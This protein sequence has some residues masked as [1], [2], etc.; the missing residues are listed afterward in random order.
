[1]ADGSIVSFHISRVDLLTDRR[2][3]QNAL[4]LFGI[5]KDYFPAHVDDPV[6]FVLFDYLNVIQVLWRHEP[7]FGRSAGAWFTGWIDEPPIHV[8]E[9]FGILIQLVGRKKIGYAFRNPFYL[10]DQHY[11]IGKRPLA[12]GVGKGDFV[13]GIKGDPDPGVTEYRVPMK[14]HSSSS[15]HSVTSRFLRRQRLTFIACSPALARTRRTVFLST[16]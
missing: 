14:D 9:R 3:S 7:C 8:K 11:G 12:N 13:N 16:L 1:V 6:F 5:P 15:W 4:D 2:A 10:L